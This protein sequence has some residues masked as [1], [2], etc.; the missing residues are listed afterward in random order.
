MTTRKRRKVANYFILHT[1]RF[2]T[3]PERRKKWIQNM[4]RE[5]WT[6]GASS[7]LC[8]DHFLESCYDRS[9]KV[10]KLREDT[11]PTRF[12]LFP[13]YMKKVYSNNQYFI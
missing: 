12:K 13:K 9:G 8:S 3:D 6:P 2:P 7:R 4:R 11:I 1:T 10:T 5:Q